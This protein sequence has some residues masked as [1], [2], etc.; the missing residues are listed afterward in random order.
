MQ[1]N[2]ESWAGEET[3]C[4]TQCGSNVLSQQQSGAGTLRHVLSKLRPGLVGSVF[5]VVAGL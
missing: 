1:Q 4:T 3:A 2:R 5:L